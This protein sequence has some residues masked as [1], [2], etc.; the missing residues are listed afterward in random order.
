MALIST[1]PSLSPQY[2]F[3]DRCSDLL[4]QTQPALGQKIEH[5]VADRSWQGTVVSALHLTNEPQTRVDLHR[6]N[7]L[8]AVPHADDNYLLPLHTI[9]IQIQAIVERPRPTS[10]LVTVDGQNEFD[11]ASAKLV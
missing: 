1:V 10:H 8:A 7:Q 5:L 2:R 4:T 6:T 11:L 9:A 3:Y